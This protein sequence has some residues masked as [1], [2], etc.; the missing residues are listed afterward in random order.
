MLI[1]LHKGVSKKI[2]RISHRYQRH[3]WCT[4]SC[5]YLRKFSKEFKTALMVYS[6]AWGKLIYKKNLKSKISW[7]CSFYKANGAKATIS[8][9]FFKKF[10]FLWNELEVGTCDESNIGILDEEIEENKKTKVRS[11]EL[12]RTKRRKR[13]QSRRKPWEKTDMRRKAVKLKGRKSRSNE[14]V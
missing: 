13:K 12:R 10:V 9:G 7:P 14:L 5:E 6:G 1:L 2:I 8:V 4:L 3:Q 11:K